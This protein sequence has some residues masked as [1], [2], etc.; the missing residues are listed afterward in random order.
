M[1]AYLYSI[2][3]ALR[4]IIT[5]QLP[6]VRFPDSSRSPIVATCVNRHKIS[7]L[8][9]CWDNWKTLIKK[10]LHTYLCLF[11]LSFCQLPWKW[12]CIGL[13][14]GCFMQGVVGF[15]GNSISEEILLYSGQGRFGC[16]RPVVMRCA[17]Y[18]GKFAPWTMVA[19]SGLA[20]DLYR[21][22][23]AT[24]RERR[25]NPTGLGWWSVSH[26]MVHGGPCTASNLPD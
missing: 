1:F 15:M 23:W 25:P 12:F 26:T 11:Q 3:V 20:G 18:R 19:K 4:T 16:E 14:T 22:Q 21:W 6:I 17:D 8:R 24:L 2:Q 10:H 5:R 9:R 13:Q 7:L